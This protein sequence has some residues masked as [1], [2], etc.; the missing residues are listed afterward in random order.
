[1]RFGTLSKVYHW[2]IQWGGFQGVNNCF[3][4]GYYPENWTH[5]YITPIHKGN[6][7]S[8]PNNYRGITITNSLGKL[9]MSSPVP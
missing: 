4:M 9:F 7:P 8:D 3:T 2:W 5:G 6:D 1:M